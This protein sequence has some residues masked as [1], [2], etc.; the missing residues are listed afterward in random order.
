MPPRTSRGYATDLGDLPEFWGIASAGWNLQRECNAQRRYREACLVPHPG[1]H[2][3]AP[4]AA[5]AGV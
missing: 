4:E 1:K 5:K 3:L 2:V